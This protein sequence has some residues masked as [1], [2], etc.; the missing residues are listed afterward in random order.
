MTAAE[1]PTAWTPEVARA[2][3]KPFDSQQVGKLPRGGDDVP[4]GQWSRCRECKQKTPPNHFHVDYI[5]HAV[6]TDRLNS[7]VG[8]AGW[9][10]TLVTVERDQGGRLLAVVGEMTVLEHTKGPEI[11]TPAQTQREYGDA[12]KSAISDYI[13]RAAMRFGV[14]LDLWAKQQLESASAATQESEDNALT[15]SSPSPRGVAEGRDSSGPSSGDG[16]VAAAQAAVA[17]KRSATSPAS[18]DGDGPP[19]FDHLTSPARARAWL[20]GQPET[21]QAAVAETVGEVASASLD[22]LR[23]AIEVAWR[24]QAA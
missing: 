17:G 6:V 16:E 15:D 21:L 4:K 12:L 3:A 5:G 13:C 19:G 22:D 7:V 23:T 20:R 14:A 18:P 8:P 9:S 2:L 10:W 24:K 1:F 11:G